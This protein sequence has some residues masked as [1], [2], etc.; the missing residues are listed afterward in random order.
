MASYK[1]CFL[2]FCYQN[3]AREYENRPIVL[4]NESNL[5]D[6]GDSGDWGPRDQPVNPLAARGTMALQRYPGEGLSAAR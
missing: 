4:Q 2:I 1:I 3:R 6:F 5:G